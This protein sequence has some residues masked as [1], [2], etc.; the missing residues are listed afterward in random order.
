MLQRNTK[1]LQEPCG[2]TSKKTAFFMVTAVKTSNLTKAVVIKFLKV[3]NEKLKFQSR[4][5]NAFS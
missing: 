4:Q 3:K 1:Y 2:V 5:R